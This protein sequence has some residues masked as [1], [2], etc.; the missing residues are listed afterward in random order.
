MQVKPAVRGWLK[1]M[2]QNRVPDTKTAGSQTVQLL[3]SVLVRC[4]CTS[5]KVFRNVVCS[6]F[7]SFDKNR[8][9]IENITPRIFTG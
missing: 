3:V 4:W 2:L 9:V 1:L 7:S 5:H 8:N 6:E